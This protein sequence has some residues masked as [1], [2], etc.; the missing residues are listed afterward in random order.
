MKT[1]LRV[2]ILG[3]FLLGACSI[4]CG[5]TEGELGSETNWSK[6]CDESSECGEN[7]CICGACTRSCDADADCAG[8]A[9]G[10]CATLGSESQ[11]YQCGEAA[12][13]KPGICL[14]RCESAR[15]CAAGRRCIA[16]SCVTESDSS[17]DPGD[18][19]AGDGG[20]S[21][22]DVEV[23]IVGVLS[24]DLVPKECIEDLP[25]L[26][27][28]CSVDD[29]STWGLDCDGD[30]V[31]D[32]RAYDCVTENAERPGDFHGDYDCVVDDQKL[33]YWVTPDADGD[34]VGQGTP[35]CA[36]PVVPE[37]FIRLTSAAADLQDCDDMDPA[38][39]PGAT[40]TWG[41]GMNS[42]CYNEDYPICSVI[43][44][45]SEFPVELPPAT[46]CEG[47]DLYFSG[48]AVCADRCRNHGALYGFVVNAGTEA[49]AESITLSWRD[50]DGNADSTE[51]SGSLGTGEATPL[52]EVPFD[53]VTEMTLTIDAEG[54]CDSSNNE[55]VFSNPSGD[56]TCL[57]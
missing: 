22:D 35:M 32:Y 4:Q 10:V 6:G 31:P 23:V 16:G 47:V 45:G 2:R 55:Y 12:E 42:D 43:E 51:L 8:L 53:L 38:V 25:E 33:R 1:K 19:G 50:Q 3:L 24:N 41:D 26:I 40:D 11:V 9:R 20:S 18:G 14:P 17:L 7:A 21:S 15:D 52:F 37:G 39:Y 54:D 13:S 36:G 28:G 46:G 30:S 27:P 56:Q 5:V 34:G 49:S 48:P 29:S 44:A 57:F